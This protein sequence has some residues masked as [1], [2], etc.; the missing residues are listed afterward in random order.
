MSQAKMQYQISLFFIVYLQQNE[1]K[2]LTF[3]LLAIPDIASD[4]HQN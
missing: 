1:R 4:L 2:M 3:K